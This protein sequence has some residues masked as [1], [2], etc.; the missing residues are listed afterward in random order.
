MDS[1]VDDTSSNKDSS[2]GFSLVYSLE[3][4]GDKVTGGRIENCRVL[5]CSNLDITLDYSDVFLLMKQHGRIEKIK[6][7]AVDEGKCYD[8]YVLFSAHKFAVL[9]HRYL[10]GH[11]VNG[12]SLRTSL[13]NEENVNFG[14]V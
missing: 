3:H 8:G 2:S 11:S 12:K 14:S 1:A 7:K 13:Y 6:L 9:A 4:Q 10:N 5:Y